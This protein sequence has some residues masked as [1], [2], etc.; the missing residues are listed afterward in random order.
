[1]REKPL[2]CEFGDR[3]DH[4]GVAEHTGFHRGHVKVLDDTAHLGDHQRRGQYGYVAHTEGVL[5][6]DCGE[7]GGAVNAEGGKGA[8]V[9]LNAS[10]ATRIRSRDGQNGDRLHWVHLT[11]GRRYWLR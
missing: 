7:C 6:G 8:K 3:F 2:A 5:G 10:S 1:M 9:A 11:E 4:V